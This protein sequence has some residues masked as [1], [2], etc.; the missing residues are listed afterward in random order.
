MSNY[1]DIRAVLKPVLLRPLPPALRGVACACCNKTQSSWWADLPS[2]GE[3][4]TYVCALCVMYDT[5]WGQLTRASIEEVVL[6][7]EKNRAATFAKDQ[8]NRLTRARDADDVQGVVVLADRVTGVR[9]ITD[10]W[11]K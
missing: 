5:A 1:F 3:D 2:E 8:S 6:E 7:I 9:K 10:R 11:K 4:K